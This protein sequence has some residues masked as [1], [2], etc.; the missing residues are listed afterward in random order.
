MT[1]RG[2]SI[3]AL[4]LC[5][6]AVYVVLGKMTRKRA[7]EKAYKDIVEKF[8]EETLAKEIGIDEISN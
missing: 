8:G 3:H 5:L 6:V 7:E 4:W 1:E 2:Q